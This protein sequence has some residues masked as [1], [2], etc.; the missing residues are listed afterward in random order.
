[1]FYLEIPFYIKTESTNNFINEIIGG[2]GR[3]RT[4]VPKQSDKS[5]YMFSLSF[6]LNLEHSGKQDYSSRSL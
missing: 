6:K 3:N 2:G 4:A 1:M 5:R